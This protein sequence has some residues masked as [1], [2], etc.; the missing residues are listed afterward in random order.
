M[1][2]FKVGFPRPEQRCRVHIIPMDIEERQM[3]LEHL[4]NT[5]ADLVYGDLIL[6]LDTPDPRA[7]I[8]GEREILELYDYFNDALPR[9]FQSL[10]NGI[11]VEYWN[12]PG[13]LGDGIFNKS[14]IWVDLSSVREE[15]LSNIKI[16]RH[17]CEDGQR[18]EILTSFTVEDTCYRLF[19]CVMADSDDVVKDFKKHLCF[20]GPLP[21]NIIDSYDGYDCYEDNTFYLDSH[22]AE[23][24]RKIIETVV[25][26]IQNMK[27]ARKI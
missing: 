23:T 25:N 24:N 26:K 12:I 1:N 6:F 21:L 4:V 20:P 13:Q 14:L 3:A 27:S 22:Y 5:N 10:M 2:S 7:C 15:A 18:L 17:G 9:E 8:C 16:Q 19:Y 11:S